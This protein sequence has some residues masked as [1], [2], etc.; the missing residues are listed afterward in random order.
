MGLRIDWITLA[1]LHN[2]DYGLESRIFGMQLV[3]NECECRSI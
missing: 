3:A 2:R 1:N